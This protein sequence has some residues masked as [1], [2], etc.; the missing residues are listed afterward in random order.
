MSLTI[1]QALDEPSAAQLEGV[2][3]ALLESTVQAV[4]LFVSLSDTVCP[5]QPAQCHDRVLL[6]A[7]TRIA[8]LQAARALIR[9]HANQYAAP[10]GTAAFSL[11]ERAIAP[12]ASDADQTAAAEALRLLADVVAASGAGAGALLAH[13][14]PMLLR[15]LGS[16]V[17]AIALQELTA[18]GARNPNEF[19]QVMGGVPEADR[20]KLATA[21]RA[22]VQPTAQTAA[23]APVHVSAAPTIQLKMDFSAFKK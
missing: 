6:T 12:A 16:P 13:I 2:V 14:L 23:A 3:V 21:V 18:T 15:A 20:L 19:R 8:A 22:S 1:T 17:H 9:S 11:F 10:F 4:R 7:Q 5:C